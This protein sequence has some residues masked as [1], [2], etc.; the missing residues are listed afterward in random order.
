MSPACSAR[1]FSATARPLLHLPFLPATCWRGWKVV[2]PKCP[3]PRTQTRRCARGL[4]RCPAFPRFFRTPWA[5]FSISLSGYSQSSAGSISETR[6]SGPRPARSSASSPETS[7]QASPPRTCR[8]SIR[9]RTAKHSA[10]SHLY[11]FE[12]ARVANS[13]SARARSSCS[14]TSKPSS[15]QLNRPSNRRRMKGGAPSGAAHTPS[16]LRTA[17]ASITNSRKS[18]WASCCW[19]MRRKRSSD[20]V[21]AGVSERTRAR[22][23]S[24]KARRGGKTLRLRVPAF[25]A[26]TASAMKRAASSSSPRS[27]ARRARVRR[28]AR[29]RR[30]PVARLGRKRVEHRERILRPPLQHPDQR[31]VRRVPGRG[32]ASTRAKP[33]RPARTE[34]RD[35]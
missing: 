13:R 18:G 8:R 17:A 12:V 3:D 14:N 24:V 2:S 25:S 7:R 11:P 35:R 19:P 30:L 5:T 16:P 15:Q 1:R 29:P 26:A 33:S 31:D 28:P 6:V 23:E 20:A 22:S 10:A 21:L 27:I 4:V 34:T 32:R 9:P